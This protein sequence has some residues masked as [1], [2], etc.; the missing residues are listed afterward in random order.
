MV[1]EAFKWVP[2][3]PLKS[4][5]QEEAWHLFLWAGAR[6]KGLLMSDDAWIRRVSLVMGIKTPEKWSVGPFY[7]WSL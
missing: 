5:L 6:Y 3:M 4:I 2:L 1:W 7:T